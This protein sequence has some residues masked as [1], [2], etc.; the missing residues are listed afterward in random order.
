MLDISN[1]P[2]MGAKRFFCRDWAKAL[3]FMEGVIIIGRTTTKGEELIAQRG[4]SDLLGNEVSLCHKTRG[5]DLLQR[6]GSCR[7]GAACRRPCS[8]RR[9]GAGK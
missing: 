7:K 1:H 4:H 9:H 8:S 6:L 3:K 5:L 2:I